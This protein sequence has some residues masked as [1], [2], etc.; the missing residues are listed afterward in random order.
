MQDPPQARVGPDVEAARTQALARMAAAGHPIETP[1]EVVAD[2]ELPFMGYTR[3][4]DDRFRIVVSGGALESGR[5]D[6]L[7]LHELSH[8]RR[9]ETRHPSHSDA[10]I[11]DVLAGLPAHA[12]DTDLKREVLHHLVNNVEDL[13]ADDVAFPVFTASGAMSRDEAATF[14]QEWVESEPA[15]TGDAERDRWWNAWLMANNARALGQMARHGLPDADGKAAEAN[16]RLLARLPPHVADASPWF[17]ARARDL[18][19]DPTPEA[20]AALLG[21][22]L[23]RYLHLVIP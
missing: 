11:T 4:M 22:Y 16:A 3:P 17:V 5:A 2:P 20:F 10:L 12:Q 19:D 14:L 18:P 9:M 23:R 13:Y 21:E 8:I 15:Q 6:T 7:L 1:V